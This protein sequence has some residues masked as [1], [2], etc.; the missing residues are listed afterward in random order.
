[1]NLGIYPANKAQ[2]YL[3]F[4][5]PNNSDPFLNKL[6]AFF[7]GPFCHVEMAF[8]E[9]YGEEPW[10]KEIWGSSIFQGETVF[11]KPKTYKREGYV[12]FAIE[13]SPSQLYKIRSFCKQQM[14][15]KVPFCIRSM[16]AAY[17]PF[18]IYTNDSVT[19]CSKHVTCA[20]Q[21]G[22]IEMVFGLSASSMTPSRLYNLL[23]SKTPIVQAVPSKMLPTN[24]APCCLKLIKNIMDSHG[25]SKQN[26]HPAIGHS[27][28]SVA[29]T[30]STYST[31][32]H[33]NKIFAVV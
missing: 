6:V 25:A 4:Y 32:I 15:S 30:N 2:V 24:I 5:K 10:E 13:V 8:P 9:R 18:T 3:L 20:L 16:Y 31:T 28:M 12:S 1:M 23:R 14:T 22:G 21:Y 17:L 26:R 33:P 11:F 19:F 29:N 27:T 7:D